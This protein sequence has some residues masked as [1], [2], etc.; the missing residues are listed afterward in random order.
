MRIP[1]LVAPASVAT[2][3]RSIPESVGISPQ[4][5]AMALEDFHSKGHATVVL[6]G[7]GI[8]VESNIPDYRGRASNSKCNIYLIGSRSSRNVHI[9]QQLSADIL[10]RVRH[11]GQS[12]QAILVWLLLLPH[13]DYFLKG[14]K[15]SWLSSCSTSAAQ[16]HASI[17]SQTFSKWNR[18]TSHYSECCYRFV[19]QA[20]IIGRRSFAW[21]R[22]VMSPC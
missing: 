9:E 14:E 2:S 4:Q 1:Y 11:A 13:A 8:S 6:S 18:K 5:A 21:R 22:Q 7:A 17:T 10:S 16:F 19:V 20:N 15:L 12:S 3:L